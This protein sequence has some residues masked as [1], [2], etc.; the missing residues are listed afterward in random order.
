[1]RTGTLRPFF[2]VNSTVGSGAP[3]ALTKRHEAGEFVGVVEDGFP[4]ADVAFDVAGHGGFEV[5]G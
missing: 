5:G 2:S 1:M 4:F 3:G